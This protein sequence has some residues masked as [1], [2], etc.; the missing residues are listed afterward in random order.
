MYAPMS[1][2]GFIDTLNDQIGAAST[3]PKASLAAGGAI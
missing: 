3:T 2:S 1:G